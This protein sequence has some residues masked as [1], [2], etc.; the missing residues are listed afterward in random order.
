MHLHK[1]V[2]VIDDDQKILLLLEKVLTKLGCKTYV[3]NRGKPGLELVKKEKP[4]I[5]ICDMFL[6]DLQGADLLKKIKTHPD[7]QHMKV[8]LMTAV[9]KELS[10]E[11]GLKSLAD[12]FIEKPIDIK[13]MVELI[14]KP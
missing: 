12:G 11:P 1:R 2:A 6:P 5:L 8:I 10:V 13:K 14:I 9:Y 7:L 3:A 4:D